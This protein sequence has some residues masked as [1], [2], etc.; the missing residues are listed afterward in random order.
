[1][2]RD[3]IQ[4]TKE[5]LTEVVQFKKKV[6]DLLRCDDNLTTALH[7][8]WDDLKPLDVAVKLAYYNKI[9]ADIFGE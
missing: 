9:K 7:E 5:L 2:L 1:M 3:R 8:L 4:N 6:I